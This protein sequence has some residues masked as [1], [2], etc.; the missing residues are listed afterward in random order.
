[1]AEK[2]IF[3]TRCEW[4]THRQALYAVKQLQLYGADIAGVVFNRA[5]AEAKY[6]A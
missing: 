2:T 6:A 4:T 1:L 3:V 5:G